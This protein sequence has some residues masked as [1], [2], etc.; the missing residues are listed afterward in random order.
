MP[1]VG[2][3]NFRRNLKE[4][5]P[6]LGSSYPVGKGATGYVFN[7]NFATDLID[8]ALWILTEFTETRRLLRP[9]PSSASFDRLEELLLM[10]GPSNSD[11]EVTLRGIYRI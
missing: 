11:L 1:S 8:L 4:Y 10:N 3:V 2:K 5:L 9:G 7:S 6:T